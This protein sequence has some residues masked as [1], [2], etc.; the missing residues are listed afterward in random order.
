MLER[1]K[2]EGQTLV[3]DTRLIRVN[4][5][6]SAA[7]LGH[8]FQICLNDVV[9]GTEVYVRR[10]RINIELFFEVS[11]PV[12]CIPVRS[13]FWKQTPLW[14]YA[15]NDT[16]GC[17]RYSSCIY[18][19]AYQN[20]IVHATTLNVSRDKLRRLLMRHLKVRA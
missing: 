9:N 16:T 13:G 5:I 3:T 20:P 17:H 8:G 12:R 14:G 15:V 1:P 19:E 10:G 18:L 2:F 6:T 4:Q 11:Q 7:V